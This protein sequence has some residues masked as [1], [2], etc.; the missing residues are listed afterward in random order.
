MPNFICK[1]CGLSILSCIKNN[2]HKNAVIEIIF[3]RLIKKI[4]CFYKI[5]PKLKHY[6]LDNNSICDG[7]IDFKIF[8]KTPSIFE[9]INFIK[10]LQNNKLKELKELLLL[11]ELKNEN[12]N[13]TTV[14]PSG[15]KSIN[16]SSI[17]NCNNYYKQY[18]KCIRDKKE[19]HVFMFFKTIFKVNFLYLIIILTGSLFCRCFYFIKKSI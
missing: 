16:N 15:Y 7:I 18:N 5:Q 17:Y 1:K 19:E 10:F 9:N 6:D 3:S 11:R 13:Y 12:T 14:K 4:G 8:E 2:K